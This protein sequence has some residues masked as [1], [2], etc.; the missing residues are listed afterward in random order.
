MLPFLYID[1]C[2]QYTGLQLYTEWKIIWTDSVLKYD[3]SGVRQA[4]FQ[5]LS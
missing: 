5:I 2:I 4:M 3:F 1:L